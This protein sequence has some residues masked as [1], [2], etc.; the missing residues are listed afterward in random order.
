MHKDQVLTSK[1]LGSIVE[2]LQEKYGIPSLI[3]NKL[4]IDIITKIYK[5]DFPV[6]LQEDGAY[7]V[8]SNENE[9]KYV[10]IKYSKDKTKKILDLLQQ[11]GN[12]YYLKMQVEK[13]N[14]FLT[15]KKPYLHAQFSHSNKKYDYYDVYYDL[16]HKKCLSNIKACIEVQHYQ[17]TKKD[18][19]FVDY[20]AI[21]YD[22]NTA[23]VKERKDFLL[24]KNAIIVIRDI[25]SEIY[26]KTNK[27]LW[28]NVRNID[29]ENMHIFL[30]IPLKT[31]EAI[32]T[33]IQDRLFGIFGLRAVL[34]KS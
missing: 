17:E 12:R 28:V 6:V 23:Y 30:N 31:N 3:L 8:F 16:E 21:R 10:K 14:S 18:R 15:T 20:T 2:E 24:R 32:L 11:E 1:L 4:I 27:K 19:I 5:P 22:K 34:V 25:C 9:L 29:K 13:M 33:Y 26:K 7:L